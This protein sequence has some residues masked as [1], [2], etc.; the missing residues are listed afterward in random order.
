[1]TQVVAALIIRD[2][3]TLIC[4]RRHDA[5]FPLKWEFPG[6]KVAANETLKAA[7]AREL[8]EELGVQATIGREI[9]K[10]TYQYPGRDEPIEVIFFSAQ[11]GTQAISNPE[12][13]FEQVSWVMAGDLPKF[14]FLTANHDLISRLGN[15]SLRAE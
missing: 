7:L 4:Q 12:Q 11:I 14:D 3:R 5:A 2:S 15:G 8:N 13:A 10:T 6:G 9:Y 1:V